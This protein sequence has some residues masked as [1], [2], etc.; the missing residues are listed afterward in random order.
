MSQRERLLAVA[1]GIL[2]V[3]F[4][5]NMGLR[6]AL[7]TLTEKE[8]RVDGALAEL[9]TLTNSIRQG[10]LAT[11]RLKTLE[12]KSLPNN[13]EAAEAQYTGW[14]YELADK[15]GMQQVKVVAQGRPVKVVPKGQPLGTPEAYTVHEFQLQGLCRLDRVIEL[16]GNYYDR[17]YL[18]RINSLKFIPTRETGLVNV[19]LSSQAI[20]LAKASP[21]QE[22]SLESSG[23]LA[24]S[25]ADYQ[26]NILQRNPLGPP[27]QPP[28]FQT[29]SSHSLTI[30]QPWQLNLEATD[31]EGHA[32][33]FELVGDRA[34]L[35]AG[36][37]FRN[38]QLSWQPK[39]KGEQRVTVRAVDDGWPR[40]ESELTLVLR[41]VDPPAQ[42]PAARPTP[43]FD[44]AQQAYL[45]GL[46]SGRGGAQ[47]W[48][49]S[50][51][52]GLS[53]DIYEGAEIAIGSITA[54]VVRIHIQE[55]FWEL[56]TDGVRWTMDMNTSLLDAYRGSQVD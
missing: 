22:P 38:G 49:R 15:S 26:Q 7:N 25:I 48:I 27:N 37:T 55:D 29:R 30:G 20:S 39:E 40:K 24:M 41:A 6:K 13:R 4:L 44:P 18:H 2:L 28:A 52:E 23:R 5:A 9:E 54:K 12:R 16:L 19:D 50:R 31:P 8:D 33:S 35:P 21:K 11:D 17:D 36:L 1:V 43:Q 34:E 3:L 46:V 42:P 56:E 45:T 10:T 14:L 47:G 51:A 53:I 32:V